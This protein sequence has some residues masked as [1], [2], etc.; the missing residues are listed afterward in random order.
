MFHDR[1]VWN[2]SPVSLFGHKRPSLDVLSETPVILFD[3][4][5]GW[6]SMKPVNDIAVIYD[7]TAHIHTTI[8]DPMPCND[9]TFP[10]GKPSIDGVPCGKAS[11][12]YMGLFRLAEHNGVQAAAVDILHGDAALYKTPLAVYLGSPVIAAET[13][14]KLRRYVQSG[15]IL[16]VTGPLPTQY[17]TGEACRFLGGLRRG[18]NPLGGGRVVVV[19]DYMAQAAC[20][21]DPP[22]TI[23][24][25]GKIL[26]DAGVTPAVRITC[27]GQQWV[28]W[29]SGGGLGVYRQDRMLGSAVLQVSEE[30]GERILFVL[31]HYPD[32]HSFELTFSVPCKKLI[33]LTEES[34]ADVKD[35]RVSLDI[36]RK[37]CQIYRVV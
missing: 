28:D 30:T 2:D 33:C 19:G 15:G 27:E 4:I 11:L 1:D 10:V 16:V 21:E 26:A 6:E 9:S 22:E 24:A 20:E 34:D 37:N 35:G 14:D 23:E 5:K 29:K 8:G 36:D 13:E 12:E 31:N 7:L 25:F 3:K 32:A 18:E 17:E